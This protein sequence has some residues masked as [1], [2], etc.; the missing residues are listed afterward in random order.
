MLLAKIDK[1]C[2]E[3]NGQQIVENISFEVTEGQRIALIGQNGVGKTS[4][5]QVLLGNL[6]LAKGTFSLHVP[7]ESIGVLQQDL[8]MFHACTVREVVEQQNEQLFSLKKKLAHALERWEEEGAKT[9]IIDAYNNILQQYIEK[10]GYEWEEHVERNLKQMGISEQL[11]DTCFDT[12]SG[13]QKTRAG[14]AR[15]LMGNP[16]FLI[17]DEP[18]NHIDME[19][20][21]WLTKWLKSFVGTVLF[22]S[23]DRAFI[24]DV[25]TTTIELTPKGT[26]VYHGGYTFYKCQK[27]HERKT[28]QSLYEKQE[29]EKKKLREMIAIYKNWY[30]Q[31]N[32]AAS[33]RDPFAQRRAAKG[34]VKYKAKEQAL[35][36]L[37]KESIDRPVEAKTIS[38]AFDGEAFF[39][40]RFVQ[41]DHVSFSYDQEHFLFK[42]VQFT[43]ERGERIGLVGKNGSGKTTLLKIVTKL[44]QPTKGTVSHH[45]Q[46]KISYFMQELDNLKKDRTILEEVMSLSAITQS[47]ARTIL[48][49]FLFRKEDVY[50]KISTL[51]MGEKCRVAFVKLYF[52]DAD[53]LVL[54]EPTNYLD[55]ETREKIEEA[56][57]NYKGAIL[58]VSH[59]VYLLRRL[60]N[61]VLFIEDGKVNTYL[62]TYQEWENKDQEETITDD[63]EQRYLLELELLHLLGQEEQDIEKIEAIQQQLKR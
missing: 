54:D 63:N 24:D 13:G 38:T 37:E 59:D 43:I 30:Q 7:K 12:L 14:L 51:S 49:C 17:L 41:V 1:G 22:I 2:I 15:V 28:E 47:E 60:C 21:Q 42:D 53:L 9:E 45:P 56:L 36:R 58:V 10:N 35:K 32:A 29:K 8:T 26:N 16:R 40:R 19:T 33:V 55:I 6:T 57:D 34:A 50:K 31:A 4:L 25:A 27:E 5:I 62:G 61:K 23:H 44:L 20:V 39:A 3:Y 46:L 18:T 11:W 48:A 52:S